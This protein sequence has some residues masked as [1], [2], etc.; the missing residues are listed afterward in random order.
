VLQDARVEEIESAIRS[1]GLFRAKA[2]ALKKMA[3]QLVN[4][5]SSRVP[6]TMAELTRLSGVGRK[7]AN[8]I[9]G[10]AFDTPGVVV[11]THVKRLARRLGLTQRIEPDKIEKDLMEILPRKDWTPVSHRLILHGRRVCQAM[12]PRCGECMLQDL[13]PWEGKSKVARHSS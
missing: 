13:C 1:L 4:Q 9:L 8:V 10:Y 11:D 6:S 7:T 5:F 2:R 3:Q 12:K